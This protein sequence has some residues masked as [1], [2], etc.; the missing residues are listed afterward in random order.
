MAIYERGVNRH[1]GS[2]ELWRE[3]LSYTANVKATKRWRKTMTN[4]LRMMPTDADLWVMAGRRSAKNGDMAAARGFFMRGCR[5]CTTDSCLWIEY[6]R[7][8]M[9]WLN[10][11]EQKK[12]PGKDVTSRRPEADD[13]LLLDDSDDDAEDED[14]V[15]MPEPSRQQAKVISNE[16]AQQLAAN[17]AMDG[18]IPIA[19]FDISRKQPFFKPEVAEA[20][21]AMLA[22]F[23]HLSVQTK[24]MQHVLNVLDQHYPKDPVTCSCHI[25]R[26]IMGLSAFTAEFPRQLRE[27]LPLVDKHLAITSDK[28]ALKQKT[29]QWIDEYLAMEG[30]DEGIKAVLEHT[31]TKLG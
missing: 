14:G 6:A 22:T 20:F 30:L 21:F 4:A 2:G 29:A 11:M 28:E 7:C 25:R 10:K 16:T 1:P 3:Y 15:I 9:E 13:E 27:V 12:K 8:E 19:I 24:V 26:P 17:P 5:F 23:R 31:R 18:A